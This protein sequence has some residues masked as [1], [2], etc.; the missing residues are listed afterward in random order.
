MDLKSIE[1]VGFKS[2]ADRV[3]FEIPRGITAIIGPNGCGKSNILDAIRWVL[4]EQRPRALRGASMEDVIFNGTDVRRPLGMA[5]VSLTLTGLD[6]DLGL[7]YEEVT[8]TRRLFRSGDSV[9]LLNKTP[10]RLRDIRELFMDTG[11]GRTAY[12]I[13]EQGRIDLILSS[14]P[15]DRREVFEEAAGVTR[16]KQQKREALRKLEHT[17][18]NLERLATIIRE[19]KRQIG[20]LHRQAGKARRYKELQERLRVLDL[21]LAWEQRSALVD[22]AHKAADRARDLAAECRRLRDTIEQAEGQLAALRREAEIADARAGEARQVRAQA[23]AEIERARQSISFCKERLGAIEQRAQQNTGDLDSAR[24]KLLIHQADLEAL[25]A[26]RDQIQDAAN[27]AQLAL[28]QGEA[29]LASAEQQVADAEEKEREAR[30]TRLAVADETVHARNDAARLDTSLSESALRRERLTAENMRTG[31]QIS[32]LAE[33]IGECQAEIR[34]RRNNVERSQKRIE[35]LER[36]ERDF[37]RAERESIGRAQELERELAALES[38]IGALEELASTEGAAAEGPA[39]LLGEGPDSLPADRRPRLV[40]RLVHHLEVAPADLAAVESALGYAVHA[41]AVDGET[42]LQEAADAAWDLARGHAWFVL[43]RAAEKIPDTPGGTRRLAESVTGPDPYDRLARDLLADWVVAPSLEQA[44]AL[45]SRHPRIS[46]ATAR[47]DIVTA[48]GIVRIGRDSEHQAGPLTV[49]RQIESLHARANEVRSRADTLRAEAAGIERQAEES[50]A[51]LASARTALRDAEVAL[52]TQEGEMAALNND[53]T[54]MERRCETIRW[55]LAALDDQEKGVSGQRAELARRLAEA[56]HRDTESAR[57]LEDAARLLDRARQEHRRAE[58]LLNERR[59]AAVLA[60]ESVRGFDARRRPL[61]AHVDD[62]RHL[63]AQREQDIQSLRTERTLLSERMERDERIL[64]E[65][66]VRI[67]ELDAAIHDAGRERERL[68]ADTEQREESLHAERERLNDKQQE[69]SRADVEAAELGARLAALD[70]RIARDHQVNLGDP[71][72]AQ[73]FLDAASE[74]LPPEPNWDEVESEV[75]ELRERLAAMGPVN[76]VAIEE[77]DEL[78]ARYDNLCAQQEDMLKARRDLHN[79]IQ[80][81][82]TTTRK[83]FA[84]TFE[85]V[86]VNFQKMFKQLFGGGHANLLLI[87][88]EDILESGIEIV[89]RPPGKKLQNVSLLSGGERTLTAVSLLFAIYMVKP[90]PFCV[91]DELDAA[92]DEA[93]IGR[94]VS[95]LGDF[96]RKSQFLIITH[97][98]QT[99]ASADVLYG[100]TMEESGVSKIVS[101]RITNRARG[102]VETAGTG[103]APAPT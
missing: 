58:Q 10:C 16:Y 90:S 12:S 36:N 84:E 98:K 86:R 101:A 5:E 4:G 17:D 31:E 34:R 63:L 14:R 50:A 26:E 91:L 9:Y 29:A 20:S 97:N 102:D 76:L 64:E 79:L 39:R 27:T 13:M 52:A 38:R 85:Q 62:L 87:D 48:D 8:V 99:I 41:W 18:Q 65:T 103:D 23:D 61:A 56:E 78:K 88:E 71:G 43:G 57:G 21:R 45:R 74:I 33:R 7:P 75:E 25:D 49:R 66:T 32:R 69:R 72:A 80:R 68:H 51:A 77:Y 46:F 2:F 42:R 54:E 19:V 67:P 100:V 73:T 60:R 24:E 28:D 22:R 47:G 6:P 37:R 82:N 92:L 44:L 40:G 89:A 94:Y 11:I 95:M 30:A 35:E 59:I 96:S 83:M 55:E 3:R 93:N 53:A 70:E 15:E 81:I 1:L